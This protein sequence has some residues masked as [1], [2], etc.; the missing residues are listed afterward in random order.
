MVNKMKNTNTNFTFFRRILA[1]AF[2][3]S[4]I[5]V[6]VVSASDSD[7]NSTQ[8]KS[9]AKSN[10][11]AVRQTG[12]Q[13]SSR[14][15][16]VYKSTTRIQQSTMDKQALQSSQYLA[17]QKNIRLRSS[18]LKNSKLDGAAS[19]SAFGFEVY[20]ASVFLI[21]DLDN[22]GF[23]SDFDIEMDVD[24]DS[25][26]ANVYAEIY[27]LNNNNEWQWLSTTDV[28][29]ISGNLASD[30][31][32]TAISLVDGFAD[33]YYDLLIDIYED[34]IP[35]IVATV[36]A[37]DDTDLAFVP[38]E[39]L[40]FDAIS[41][42]NELLLDDLSMSLFSDYD[43]DGFYSN[44]DFEISLDNETFGRRLQAVFY[45]RDSVSNW[46]LETSTA[47]AFVNRGETVIFQING[48]WNTGYETDYYDFLVEIVDLDSGEIVADY[49]PEYLTLLERPM[50]S[51]DYDSTQGPVIIVEESYSSGSSDLILM[52]LLSM[53][54]I[55]RVYRQQSLNKHQKN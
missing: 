5:S 43:L 12:K 30:S 18:D 29:S 31:Y 26:S 34:G 41:S 39:D 17:V 7:N 19:T 8:V 53:G 3:T 55:S 38:L 44:F 51:D 15:G 16:G 36:A 52:L 23:Y 22:D 28:F 32:T 10:P 48:S 13:N 2:V 49:G 27:Y 33:N 45:S 25:G 9:F 11:N 35:G 40:N 50:E 24:I 54:L 20:D 46:F 21:R 1:T 14:V 42:S 47:A 4:L 6:S 37:S